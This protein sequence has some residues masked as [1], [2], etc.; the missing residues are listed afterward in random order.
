M[1]KLLFFLLLGFVGLLLA[2]PW[3]FGSFAE[4]RIESGLSR[5]ATTGPAVAIVTDEYRRRWFSADSRHRIVLTDSD[6]IAGIRNLTGT[7]G[8]GDQPALIIDTHIDHGPVPF[9]SLERE[10]G[11]LSPALSRARS[12][13]SIDLG[14]G[15]EPI[16]LPGELTTAMGLDGS[17]QA[18][19]VLEAGSHD[20]PDGGGRLSWDGA[21]IDATI[22]ADGMSIQSK[23]SI[24]PLRLDLA[25]GGNVSVGSVTFDAAQRYSGYGLPVGRASFETGPIEMSLPGADGFSINAIRIASDSDI[26]GELLAGNS[27]ISIEELGS[28]FGSVN[29]DAD[30][31]VAN[32]HAPSLG[33]LAQALQE[34]E[35]QARPQLFEEV[36]PILEPDLARLIAAGPTLD[37][38]HLTFDLPQGELRLRAFIAVAAGQTAAAIDPADLVSRL[39]ATTDLR[40]PASL[41]EEIASMEAEAADQLQMLIGMGILREDGDAYRMEAEYGNGL[42]TI[43]GFPLP[44]PIGL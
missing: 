23:G 24:S 20:I 17:T 44:V 5:N 35:A 43:N 14:D 6:L 40:V 30:V 38:R 28:G 18:E 7:D 36:Y 42:L 19:F 16:A 15:A 4:R 2:A 13:F 31:A 12:V 26:V 21:N 1:R 39:T 11:S 3:F 22:S 34:L 8:F 9:T 25:E 29:L 33:S 27:R 32:L 37:I 10:D 41:V